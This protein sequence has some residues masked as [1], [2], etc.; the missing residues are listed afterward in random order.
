MQRYSGK[1]PDFCIDLLPYYHEKSKTLNLSLTEAN[2]QDVK[3]Y[4]IPF[5]RNHPEITT[6]NLSNN[7]LGNEGIRKFA[8]YIHNHP[9]LVALDLSN[10]LALDDRSSYALL[11]KALT[12]SSRQSL[13]TL[14]LSNCGLTVE[15]MKSIGECFPCL[16]ELDVSHNNLPSK[17]IEIL[18]NKGSLIKLNASHNL[19]TNQTLRYLIFQ[20][21]YLTELDI[22]NNDIDINKT[23]GEENVTL[24]IKMHYLTK[25]YINNNKIGDKG[26]DILSISRMKR[27]F[28]HLNVSGCG[29]SDKGILTLAASP[30]LITFDFSQNNITLQGAKAILALNNI[31]PY[32]RVSYIR[33]NEK[34]FSSLPEADKN[35]LDAA[36]KKT[37]SLLNLTIFSAGK[38]I[39]GFIDCSLWLQEYDQYLLT[40][41]ED[42]KIAKKNHTPLFYRV[43]SK[44]GNRYFLYGDP[45]G[46]DESWQDTEIFDSADINLQD[47]FTLLLTHTPLSKIEEFKELKLNDSLPEKI[48]IFAKT[49]SKLLTDGH[50]QLLSFNEKLRNLIDLSQEQL[51]ENKNLPLVKYA[52]DYD[53]D[54]KEK[55]NCAYDSN[56]CE[57]NLMSMDLK[58]QDILDFVLPFIKAHPEI[59]T[60]D[61]SNNPIG[62]ES[63]FFLAEELKD[64][65]LLALHINN[66]AIPVYHPR[67]LNLCFLDFKRIKSLT[68]IE[69]SNNHLPPE[70]VKLLLQVF[71]HLQSLNVSGNELSYQDVTSIN[72]H[73]TL[74]R[75]NMSN[76]SLGNL[77]DYFIEAMPN[78]IELDISNNKIAR[79]LSIDRHKTL[80]KLIL[81]DNLLSR[82]DNLE[83]MKNLTTLH[84]ARNA[85]G[86]G[87]SRIITSSLTDLDITGNNLPLFIIKD[88]LERNPLQFQKYLQQIDKESQFSDDQKN[89]I[90]IYYAI[91]T[92]NMN[93]LQILIN[94]F[95]HL[96]N[97]ELEIIYKC[98]PF[99]LAIQYGYTD[100]VKYF[101]NKGIL[102]CSNDHYSLLIIALKEKHD[103]IA[104]LLL[105]NG[106]YSPCI[107]LYEYMMAF[108]V[109]LT[110]NHMKAIAVLIENG[111]DVTQF[112][113]P[114]CKNSP[115]FIEQAILTGNLALLKVMVEK[116]K[117]SLDLASLLLFK[118]VHG[119][120]LFTLAAE[121]NNK[122][123]Y[124]YLLGKVLNV[125]TE[126]TQQR[127]VRTAQIKDWP[128]FKSLMDNFITM[129][130]NCL[131]PSHAFDP[132]FQETC[133]QLYKTMLSILLD[134]EDDFG[135]SLLFHAINSGQ[136]EIV[137]DLLNHGINLKFI[138]KKGYYRDKTT[139]HLACEKINYYNNDQERDTYLAIA[140]ALI[141]K[142]ADTSSLAK[143]NLMM[144]FRFAFNAGDTKTIAIMVQ[145]GIDVTEL[146]HDDHHSLSFL[147]YASNMHDVP[148]LKALIEGNPIFANNESNLP[149]LSIPAIWEAEKDMKIIESNLLKSSNSS[150]EIVNQLIRYQPE[151]QITNKEDESTDDD[152]QKFL[153]IDQT[154]ENQITEYDPIESTTV[155]TEEQIS[156][157]EITYQHHKELPELQILNRESE[158]R[159]DDDQQSDDRSMPTEFLNQD[160]A[161]ENQIPEY[162]VQ[163]SGEHLNK[164]PILNLEAAQQHHDGLHEDRDS[165]KTKPFTPLKSNQPLIS[166]TLRNTHIVLDINSLPVE[167]KDIKIKKVG[168]NAFIH[169]A[170]LA[171][172]ETITTLVKSIKSFQKKNSKPI[173]LYLNSEASVDHTTRLRFERLTSYFT[174]EN[175][176]FKAGDTKFFHKKNVD[177][178]HPLKT[179][180]FSPKIIEFKLKLQKLID[181]HSSFNPFLMSNNYKQAVL[182]NLSDKIDIAVIAG[183]RTIDQVIHDWKGDKIIRKD[184]PLSFNEFKKN[185]LLPHNNGKAFRKLIFD[186]TEN[187]LVKNWLSQPKLELSEENIKFIYQAFK[188]RIFDLVSNADA[189]GVHRNIFFND[190]RPGVFTATEIAI[191]NLAREFRNVELSPKALP[192][193]DSRKLIQQ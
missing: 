114:A 173:R 5:L 110:N 128:I 112:I 160:Q 139:L 184:K 79:L 37:T 31:N 55:I 45:Y 158:K 60:L 177:A 22:S 186:N 8:E 13:T 87:I 181:H 167:A 159:D 75:I 156:D 152:Q 124:F 163:V 165:N 71:P 174:Y 32:Q 106:A 111:F 178:K 33:H 104:S 73:K 176:V 99:L 164:V 115:S 84:I 2:A 68:T 189:I 166:D 121:K 80:K 101:L 27:P 4:I 116:H 47:N 35:E 170:H 78:L 72:K 28:I 69:I 95:P 65:N 85:L 44:S 36:C 183:N 62:S 180:L 122:E 150:P 171:N 57:L 74:K 88:F 50:Y 154:Y 77:F 185:I 83:K 82:S 67:K 63:I 191:N 16:I 102:S 89:K 126:N 193:S 132:D 10:N 142:G 145:N 187:I 137:D 161:S 182:R 58:D 192:I 49:L 34:A 96:L 70:T 23:D 30:A 147:Q 43:I 48:Q 38:L 52:S 6:I 92:N 1:Y 162:T 66:I 46:N 17:G 157:L 86:G 109:A 188:F 105:E 9:G 125:F 21:F 53:D 103:Y 143:Q 100:I 131:L 169:P 56:T 144:I 7:H 42:K 123:I 141:Q 97:A 94:N 81:N 41:K 120:T 117:I 172:E 25:L 18:G 76:C 64:K 133:N 39:P 54:M 175:Q 15:D 20:F 91:K 134:T 155:V 136:R 153:T 190:Q 93:E 12:E 40:L 61:L 24:L 11:F 119:V 149:A 135:F 19:L 118:N 130:Q 90:K 14:K 138:C 129:A 3:D 98:T 29:L 26:A 127:L 151:L 113:D 146:I 51:K 168:R 59:K 140:A 148:M 107:R 179:L 108:K